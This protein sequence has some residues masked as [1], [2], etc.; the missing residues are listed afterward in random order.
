MLTNSR[1]KYRNDPPCIPP[2][3]NHESPPLGG[4][5]SGRYVTRPQ[6]NTGSKRFLFDDFA[7]FA[8]PFRGSFHLSL[9]LLVRYRSL[10]NI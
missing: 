10:A 7:S 8:P 4:L 2:R 3:V 5:W 1:L 9:A 6:V